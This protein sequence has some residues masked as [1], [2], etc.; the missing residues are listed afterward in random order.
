MNNETQNTYEVFFVHIK[1]NTG[2]GLPIALVTFIYLL[3]KKNRSG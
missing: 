1:K 3:E 2:L